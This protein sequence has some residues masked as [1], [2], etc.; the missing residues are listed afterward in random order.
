MVLSIFTDF[1][2]TSKQS[3]AI[4][5]L[6]YGREPTKISLYVS[7]IDNWAAGKDA[8][9]FSRLLLHDDVT[10]SHC[11]SEMYPAE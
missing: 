9:L 7:A 11:T 1:L 2:R 6:P 10:L 8:C 3:C 5:Q 4:Y